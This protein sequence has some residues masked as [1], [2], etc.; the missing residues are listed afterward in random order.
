MICGIFYTLRDDPVPGQALFGGYQ[1]RVTV[2]HLPYTV[3]PG[4]T[5]CDRCIVSGFDKEVNVSDQLINLITIKFWVI[6][7]EKSIKLILNHC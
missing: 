2:C 4:I 3:L 5:Y 7:T 6:I 1:V